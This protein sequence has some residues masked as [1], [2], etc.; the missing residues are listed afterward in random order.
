M[1][2]KVRAT[3]N[4]SDLLAY[5]GLLGRPPRGTSP[6]SVSGMAHRLTCRETETERM[7][8]REYK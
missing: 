8:M 4:D 2:S 5:K 7:K 6:G 1:S 3:G